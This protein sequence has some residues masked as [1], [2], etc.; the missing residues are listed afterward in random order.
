MNIFSIYNFNSIIFSLI[1][2]IIILLLY[3]NFYSGH[4]RWGLSFFDPENVRILKSK[5]SEQMMDEY[6]NHK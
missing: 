4:N 3:N 5:T 2:I 1:I 6:I